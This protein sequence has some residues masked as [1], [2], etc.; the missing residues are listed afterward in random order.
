MTEDRLTVLIVDDDRVDIR[1]VRR[2]FEKCASDV[3]ILEAH[4]GVEALALLRGESDS[5][6]VD[7]PC[8]MFVDI[9]MP[10][11]N[12]FELLEVLRSDASLSH[13]VVFMLT[14]S[15]HPS[16]VEQAYGHHIAG[17][18]LKEAVAPD[19]ARVGRLVDDY[20]EVVCFPG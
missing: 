4:D 12:G 8:L 14:S 13:Y 15:D 11:M 7:E 3:R 1:M 2:A 19:Y 10:R 9:N 17:Y 6:V 18:I 20:R 5:S 16:D